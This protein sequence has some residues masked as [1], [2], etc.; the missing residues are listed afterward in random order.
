MWSVWK[1]RCIEMKEKKKT[2]AGL[3]AHGAVSPVICNKAG[4]RVQSSACCNMKFAALR[5]CSGRANGK[6]DRAVLV[7]SGFGR[8]AQLLFV[9]YYIEKK[10]K[11]DDWISTSHRRCTFIRY[12]SWHIDFL[13]AFRNILWPEP[14]ISLFHRLWPPAKAERNNWA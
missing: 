10:K 5:S 13:R 2:S 14:A 9:S 6:Y 4:S 7:S 3:I 1:L 12:V 8:A 11:S